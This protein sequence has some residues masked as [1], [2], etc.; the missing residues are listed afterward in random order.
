MFLAEDRKDLELDAQ[1]GAETI[2]LVAVVVDAC[3]L[4]DWSASD[5]HEGKPTSLS[6]ARKDKDPIHSS[7]Q[8]LHSPAS[9]P[10]RT[11]VNVR[12]FYVVPTACMSQNF[13][14]CFDDFLCRA[15]PSTCYYSLLFEATRSSRRDTGRIFFCSCQ[16]R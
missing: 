1:Q 12:N 2:D 8:L 6:R 9:L 3:H 14:V 10:T 16:G 4:G 13:R 11:V 5:S 7:A 15:T